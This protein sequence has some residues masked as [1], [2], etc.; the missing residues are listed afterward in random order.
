[1]LHNIHGWGWLHVGINLALLDK[2]GSQAYAMLIERQYIIS[3]R[4]TSYAI[5]TST[6]SDSTDTIAAT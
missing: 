5:C 3:Y 1:M 6:S 2:D 4:L